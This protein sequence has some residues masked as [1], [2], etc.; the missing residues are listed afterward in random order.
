MRGYS[1]STSIKYQPPADLP[2]SRLN[3]RFISLHNYSA[4][5]GSLK[6]TD[7]FM[8]LNTAIKPKRNLQARGEE[9]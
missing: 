3:T 1:T 7:F 8:W 6:A 5:Y 9:R 2:Y 4:S